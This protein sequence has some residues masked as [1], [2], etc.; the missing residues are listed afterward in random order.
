MESINQLAPDAMPHL[1]S[2]YGIGTVFYG[3]TNR[4][5]DGSF[6]TTEWFTVLLLP[7]IPISSFRVTFGWSDTS[8]LGL[9]S[10][11]TKRYFIHSK[12]KLSPVQVLRTYALYIGSLLL[13]AG[14]AGLTI[15][16]SPDELSNAGMAVLLVFSL[17][18]FIAF[19]VLAVRFWRAK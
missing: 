9:T 19:I 4:A 6:L 18:W 5:D 8:S 16:V 1:K 11:V 10:T 2:F 17:A 14:I 13:M 7:I 3:A 12:E 15:L